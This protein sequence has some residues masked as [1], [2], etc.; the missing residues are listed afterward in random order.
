MDI[1]TKR[2]LFIAEN[3]QKSFTRKNEISSKPR[4]VDN[5]IR[6]IKRLNEQ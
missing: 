2:Q 4:N 5:K 3:K 6:F 1:I